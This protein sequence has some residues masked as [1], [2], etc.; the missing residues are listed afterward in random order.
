MLMYERLQLININLEEVRQEEA[1][2]VNS[3]RTQD[4][5]GKAICHIELFQN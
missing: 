1:T 2:L 5:I 4:E 3:D